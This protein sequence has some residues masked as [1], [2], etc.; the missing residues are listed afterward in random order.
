MI[1]NK[2]AMIAAIIAAVL[3]ALIAVALIGTFGMVTVNA[4]E[5]SSAA[6]VDFPAA[7][8]IIGEGDTYTVNYYSPNGTKIAEQT[9]PY[10]STIPMI[11]GYGDYSVIYDIAI[12]EEE[13]ADSWVGVE[14]RNASTA[15]FYESGRY[16]GYSSNTQGRVNVSLVI[17]VTAAMSMDF[18]G[19]VDGRSITF[20][21]TTYDSA[22]DELI[23]F[24]ASGDSF[25]IT[26]LDVLDP[27][28]IM[29]SS[30]S[31]DG[32]ELIHNN[33]AIVPIYALNQTSCVDVINLI[34]NDYDGG[35]VDFLNFSTKFVAGSTEP[36]TVNFFSP[37]LK[38][39]SSTTITAD[40]TLPVL[41]GYDNYTMLQE[42]SYP[43]PSTDGYMFDGVFVDL[44]AIDN[45]SIYGSMVSFYTRTYSGFNIFGV[46]G[47]NAI[48]N[49]LVSIDFI[50]LNNAINFIPV[51]DQTVIDVSAK[52]FQAS[53]SINSF[54]FIGEDSFAVRY[55]SFQ[56]NSLVIDG[57][58][59]VREDGLMQ[60]P[61]TA[62]QLAG[63]TPNTDVINLIVDDYVA[64]D[65]DDPTTPTPGGDTG[66]IDGQD[67]PMVQGRRRSDQELVHR[68][69]TMVQGLVQLIDSASILTTTISPHTDNGSR[70]E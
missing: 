53:G 8:K 14:G 64:P 31:V 10:M 55:P 35:E 39:I 43:L 67:R 22:F 70:I 25:E 13:N 49:G 24:D 5:S 17:N 6:T 60:F 50:Y 15:R 69:G 30:F 23:Q 16:I 18:E 66:E 38:P 52:T 20:D 61:Y 12:P 42:I 41:A 54:Q 32:V 28:S 33:I 19:M 29:I 2:D 51:L 63:F 48:R 58:D 27:S 3:I 21:E 26:F 40:Q 37:D 1:R 47:T 46:N 36:V 7:T 59:Y 56:L 68:G 34:V 62:E 65:P 11:A 45:I 44:N 9:V 57:Y 4:E